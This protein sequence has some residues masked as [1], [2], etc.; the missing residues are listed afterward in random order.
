MAPFNRP[1]TESIQQ[2]YSC[3]IYDPAPIAPEQAGQLAD[4][5]ASIR[6]GPLG[7]P[8]RFELAVATEGD[9]KALQGLGTYGLIKDPPGFIIGAVCQGEKDLEDFS[10]GLEA[11][12][13]Y[14]TGLGLGTCWL[15]GNFTKSSFSR[16]IRAGRDETVPG[17]ASVGYPAPE[18]RT[19]DRLRQQARSDTRLPWGM[20][21]FQFS[22][23]T[24][25]SA[26]AAGAYALP[27]E[28]V[29]LAPSA[30][31]KQPW[32]I[33]QGGRCF[34]F[35]L[36]RTRDQQRGRRV[37]STLLGV[38]DLQRMDM[39]IAMCHFELAAR[40]LGLEGKWQIHDP[41]IQKAGDPAEYVVSWVEAG[42]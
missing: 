8:C 35:Y 9:R 21:F 4:F 1:V 12:I 19:R 14:A 33:V 5:A 28:M 42:E 23:E 27:L 29:R 37:L 31:N 7:T 13:L 18:S 11:I 39:G 32:R 36:Q 6:A 30:H 25:L 41:G 40:E 16:K 22:F 34:H 17:V 15:G 3:R 10:Y 38:A 26:A 24:P 2:R 20:L